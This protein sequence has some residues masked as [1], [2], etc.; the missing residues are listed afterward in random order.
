M[1]DRRVIRN[2]ARAVSGTLGLCAFAVFFALLAAAPH[3]RGDSRIIY[4]VACAF[5]LVV[6]LSVILDRLIVEDDGVTVVDR[7]KK[8]TFN[9]ND[10]ESVDT[11][12][13]TSPIFTGGGEIELVL[14]GN[15]RVRLRGTATFSTR[16]LNDLKAMVATALRCPIT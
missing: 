13:S 1:T 11:R 2:P 15:R 9:I 12:P 6:A 10:V 4:G 7:F 8:T 5:F 3:S 16:R 14:E